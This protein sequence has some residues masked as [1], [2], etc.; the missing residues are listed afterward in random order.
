MK[1]C[2][3]GRQSRML[4][5]LSVIGLVS[6]GVPSCGH[7]ELPLQPGGQPI[8]PGIPMCAEK[9]IVITPSADEDHPPKV[10]VNV[11]AISPTAPNNKISW[12]CN[13]SGCNGWQVIFDDSSLIDTELFGG[14]V[15][16]GDSA[17]NGRTTTD[18]ATFAPSGKV[19]NRLPGPFV[20]KYT[21]QTVGS[22]P[23]DPHIVPM[24]P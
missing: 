5:L 22:P 10:T 2:M 14:R 15:T 8:T 12:Q 4:A 7:K 16:F 3:S 19:K 21:V 6:L 1:V 23:L 20:V 9:T 11:C 24:G 18:Q 17:G 13:V